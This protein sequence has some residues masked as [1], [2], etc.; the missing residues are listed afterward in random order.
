MDAVSF[1]LG[2]K[3]KQL[4]GTRLR[5]LVYRVE[6]D[7]MEGTDE[8]RAWVQLVFLHG[9]EG[10]ERELL[11]R[12]EITPAGSSEYSINGKVVSWDAYDARLTALIE[13]ISGSDQLS[14]EY[15]RLADEKNKAE[16]N[17]IFNFQKRKGI[18]AEKKQYKEQKEEAERFNE[19]VKTQVRVPSLLPPSLLS[20]LSYFCCESTRF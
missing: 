2:V 19:L 16:E 6:G 10:E 18:S 9:P 13:S 11:F 4:R 3:T 15:D 5:D 20:L 8:E 14:E 1:V 12:R 7:Q 17:T